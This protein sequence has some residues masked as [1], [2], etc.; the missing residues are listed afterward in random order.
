M[1]R[2]DDN[3]QLD[4]TNLEALKDYLKKFV[5]DL[6]PYWNDFV[7]DVLNTDAGLA[8]I[9][10]L[11]TAAI[12]STGSVPSVFMPFIYSAISYLTNRGAAT[13]RDQVFKERDKLAKVAQEE[14][15]SQ[16]DRKVIPIQPIVD[17][18]S[19]ET[20]QGF[21][22]GN[23]CLF[24]VT[25]SGKT[26]AFIT[27]LYTDLITDFDLFILIG[28]D[29]LKKD[30]VEE[31]RTAV[32]YALMKQGKEYNTDVFAFYNRTQLDDGID[33]A[34]TNSGKKKLVFFDDIQLDNSSSNFQKVA[35]FTQECKH[36]NCTVF[37]SMHMTYNDKGAEIIR[38]SA[39]YFCLFNQ[40]EQNFNRLL[41]IEKG[42]RLWRKYNL[43]SDLH[44]RVLIHDVVNRKNF[45]GTFPYTRMDPLINSEASN[46]L[47]SIP[48]QI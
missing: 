37:T 1:P 19:K 8:I 36:A 46:D 32:Q 41:G 26:T 25:Q 29:L 15:S 28:S 47:S 16:E 18:A 20:F 10:G 24:G 7:R 23:V 35:L 45:F 43:I 48:M 12:F 40:H 30:K 27:W 33:F 22:D 34:T 3:R 2:E 6:E 4:I 5:P 42:N 11:M 21:D 39:K 17:S 14:K 9:N 38:S 31:I 13:Y 44:E